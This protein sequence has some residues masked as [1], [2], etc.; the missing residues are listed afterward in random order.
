[1]LLQTL[2]EKT[3][4]KTAESLHKDL[5]SQGL[6]LSA[7]KSGGGWMRNVSVESYSQILKE[8]GTTEHLLRVENMCKIAG[9]SPIAGR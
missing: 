7:A 5:G 9:F 2:G 8:I 6:G 3:S 4:F 1:M